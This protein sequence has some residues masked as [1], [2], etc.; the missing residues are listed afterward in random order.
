MYNLTKAN[1]S[2]N[3]AAHNK[4]GNM[5]TDRLIIWLLAF[6]WATPVPPH[7]TP[8]LFDLSEVGQAAVLASLIVIA[9]DYVRN[10]P[11]KPNR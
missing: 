5:F 2:I 11:K 8:L 1:T 7:D 4:R 9:L 10:E 3:N 6:V